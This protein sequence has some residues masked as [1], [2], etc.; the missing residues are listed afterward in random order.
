M[1]REAQKTETFIKP[2]GAR[3]VGI[4]N[5]GM[6]GPFFEIVIERRHPTGKSLAVMAFPKRLNRGAPFLHPLKPPFPVTVIQSLICE[7]SR[8]VAFGAQVA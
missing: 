4:N 7:P 3:V 5:H 2:L 1:V 8:I 6:R